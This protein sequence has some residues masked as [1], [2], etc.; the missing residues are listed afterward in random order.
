MRRKLKAIGHITLVVFL[1][2]SL[3]ACGQQQPA[4]ESKK[5]TEAPAPVKGQSEKQQ[6]SHSI[7]IVTP[8]HTTPAYAHMVGISDLIIKQTG[9]SVNVQPIGGADAIVNAVLGKKADFGT[10][11][12]ITAAKAYFGQDQYSNISK[13]PIRL[14]MQGYLTYRYILTRADSGIMT[15]SDLRGKTIVGKRRALVDME[16]ATKA[17]LQIAG[18]SEDQVKIVETTNIIESYDALRMNSVDAILMI[19]GP[20][21]PGVEELSQALNLRFIGI[22]EDKIE[23]VKN[24]LGPGFRKVIIP[25]G[26]CKGQDQPLITLGAPMALIT[27]DDVQSDTVYKVIKTIVDNYEDVKI[28][29]ADAK[30]WNIDNTLNSPPFAFHEGA[31]K[32]FKERNMWTKELDEWQ[33]KTL[34]GRK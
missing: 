7:T 28:I 8:A 19:D 9:I 23:E 3:S 20:S 27:R 32:F 26:T 13:A 10:G 34:G 16:I 11:S 33:T 30:D 31:I 22:P 5:T 25:P 12:A 21:A 24:L 6:E 1:L 17:F 4:G 14:V 2:I 18:V 15:L 29:Q